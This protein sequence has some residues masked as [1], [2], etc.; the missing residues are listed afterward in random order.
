MGFLRQKGNSSSPTSGSDERGYI[1]ATSA[2]LLIPLMVFAA[3]AV[4]VGAWYAEADSAQRAADAAALAAAAEMPNEANARN[5]A[6]E[7]ARLNGF[8]DQPGCSGSVAACQPDTDPASPA[9]DY[10]QVIVEKINSSEVKVSIVTEGETFF[11]GVA[12]TDGIRIER[13]AGAAINRPIPMG[14]PSNALGTGTDSVY[15][16]NDPDNFWL[17]GHSA[18]TSQR[19]V[20]DPLNTVRAGNSTINDQRDD[21]GF[22]YLITIPQGTVGYDLETRL[23]C[24]GSSV[25]DLRL[26]LYN[27][28]NAG[29]PNNFDDDI[30]LANRAT[31]A[32]GSLGPRVYKEQGCGGGYDADDA[33]EKGTW[34]AVKN[35]LTPGI[36][37]L[38]AKNDNAGSYGRVLFSLRVTGGFGISC[39]TITSATCPT[40]S[41][42]NW[43]GVYT[44]E[45]MFRDALRVPGPTNGVLVP[46]ELYL[47][48]VSAENKHSTLEV[49]MFDTADG[50]SEIEIVAPTNPTS[51]VRESV[52][53]EWTL[54]GESGYTEV[55]GTAADGVPCAA[56]AGRCVRRADGDTDPFND[57]V[58]TIRVD[59]NDVGL[60]FGG[61]DCA[62]DCWWKIRYI[63]RSGKY[64][65]DTTA[66]QARIIGD[67][68][69]LTE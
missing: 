68:I 11:G 2:L 36:W 65:A 21:R 29:T 56:G 28:D 60:G 30:N 15:R 66:W 25:E 50:I 33:V 43:L 37:V 3:F 9:P 55:D 42:L 32:G 17:N 59:L 57:R 24:F 5:A 61:Y 16:T 4:D 46:V 14:T 51:G 31:H 22:I 19:G 53:L 47:A 54:V 8:D 40:I 7:V 26:T 67:P 13:F 64:V 27:P 41:P 49:T 1:L 35:D 58:V 6:E 44:D 23:S 69:R 18:T 45:A 12:V 34:Q 52:L 48:E 38:T 62:G 39:S 10:P 63:A 20:G